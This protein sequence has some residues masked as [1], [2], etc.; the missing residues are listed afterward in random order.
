MFR[1]NRMPHWP[2]DYGVG[3]KP[4][5]TLCLMTRDDICLSTDL[6]YPDNNTFKQPW[7]TVYSN[8]PYGKESL[9]G[10]AKFWTEQG[11]A[12]AAQDVRGKHESNGS[13][14]FFRTQGNDSID[15]IEY[16]IQQKWSDGYG[17]VTG[18]SADALGQY[19]DIPGVPQGG[20]GEQGFWEHNSILNH[21]IGGYLIFGDGFG[22]S[23][24]YQ[25]GAYRECLI[26]GWL[27]AI[28]EEP[29]IVQVLENERFD[30]FWYPLVGNWYVLLIIYILK[31]ICDI[32]QLYKQ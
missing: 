20:G 10:T 22:K 6:Y 12:F 2:E 16:I 3:L 11:F 29:T 23:T 24:V 28:F 13:Y 25:E 21:G 30:P 4:D 17:G 7:T 1:T 26:T 9:K 5:E 18:V 19:A 15:S 32:F 8:T 27:S 31:Y 14:A